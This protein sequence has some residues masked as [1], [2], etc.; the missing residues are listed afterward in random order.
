MDGRTGQVIGDDTGVEGC[1]HDDEPQ[2]GPRTGAQTAA[3]AKGQVDSQVALVKFVEDDGA[4]A[5]QLRVRQ[6]L[7][8]EQAF[9]EEED[10]RGVADVAFVSC[11]VAHQPPQPAIELVGNAPGHDTGGQS[12]RL[13][14][15]NPPLDAGMQQHLRHLRRLARSSG[16]R[17][18]QSAR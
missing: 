16:C 9:G 6:Q 15:E 4:D 18:H 14:Y 11:L 13:Q 2:I 3:Q 5:G 8:Q 7:T 1:R 10:T 17:Q 12:P